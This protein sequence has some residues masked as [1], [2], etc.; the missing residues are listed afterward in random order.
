MGMAEAEQLARER[1]GLFARAEPPPTPAQTDPTLFQSFVRE[2]AP[3]L[4]FL[5]APNGLG[6]AGVRLPTMPAPFRGQGEL[7]L[8]GGVARGQADF[9]LT[10]GS[11]VPRLTTADYNT[12]RARLPL[13]ASL[14][15]RTAAA[16]EAARERLA[17]GGY[18]PDVSRLR[19]PY[20][21]P[22]PMP[23][24]PG[25][26]GPIPPPGDPRRAT[27]MMEDIARIQRQRQQSVAPNAPGY[28]R[29][30]APAPAPTAPPAPAGQYGDLGHFVEPPTTSQVYRSLPSLTERLSGVQTPPRRMLGSE[31]PLNPLEERRG[32]WGIDYAPGGRVQGSLEARFDPRS[33][34][35]QVTGSNLPPEAQGQGIGQEM[36]RRMFDEAHRRGVNVISDDIQSPY[37]YRVYDKVLR[38]QGYNVE[39]NPAYYRGGSRYPH[40]APTGEGIWSVGPKEP[41]EQ[42]Q[43]Y[44]SLMDRLKMKVPQSSPYGI[45]PFAG[46]PLGATLLQ[47]EDRQQ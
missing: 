1:L 9:A 45:A 32:Y 36:Y 31:M 34:Q 18:P 19:A 21:S 3:Y 14:A 29:P 33:N 41:L 20:I 2:A 4:N 5:S 42:G 22:P 23:R 39:R 46:V 37:S 12:A 16:T 7:P 6:L 38:G 30:Q 26:T 43:P 15:D 11:A 44:W 27:W 47:P 28:T 25:P 8:P 24:S 40:H 17:Q 13:N 35:L 10:G